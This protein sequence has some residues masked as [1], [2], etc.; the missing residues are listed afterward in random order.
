MG[1]GTHIVCILLALELHKSIA[2]ML[3][4]DS[5]LGQVHIHCTSSKP[6]SLTGSGDMV[7]MIDS[8]AGQS[9]VCIVP[10]ATFLAYLMSDH[11]VMSYLEGLLV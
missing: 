3:T 1:F 4:G 5:V 11:N 8:H 7:M 9:L 2:L 6:L 10:S